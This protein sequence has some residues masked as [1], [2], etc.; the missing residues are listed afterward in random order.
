MAPP[1][2]VQPG[3]LYGQTKALQYAQTDEEGNSVTNPDAEPFFR[4][5][6]F[7]QAHYCHSGINLIASEVEATQEGWNTTVQAI[8]SFAGSSDAD[9]TETSKVQF[10]DTDIFPEQ[11]RMKLV[12]SGLYSTTERT[13]P[14]GDAAGPG[15]RRRP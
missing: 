8:G 15:P 3:L 7:L 12:Q 4:R 5:R 6:P 1:L 10:L 11:Q 9:K 13:R 2:R 14:T